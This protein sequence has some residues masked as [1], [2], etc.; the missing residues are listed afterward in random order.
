MKRANTK[1]NTRHSG[2]FT[3]VE[4]VVV[5]LVLGIIAAVA[6]PKLFDT[7]GDARINSSK[8]SLAIL[9]NAVELYKA[10]SGSY[11]AD[12]AAIQTMLKGP[13]PINQISAAVNDASLAVVTAGTA[14][15]ASGAQDWKYDSTTGE[16]II[17][18]TGYD[19][20]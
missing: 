18:T 14:L 5:I 8:Q 13:F 1:S 19:A 3:L 15:S 20:M 4:L 2:G 11:P 12:K 17:N 16:F 7:A 9:R 10:S 6:A